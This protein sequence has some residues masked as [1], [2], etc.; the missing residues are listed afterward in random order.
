MSLMIDN[1]ITRIVANN[2]VEAS[3]NFLAIG[4]MLMRPLRR[5]ILCLHVTLQ[6]LFSFQCSALEVVVVMCK[7]FVVIEVLIRV[8][9]IFRMLFHL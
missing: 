9:P 5:V 6:F 2:L 7:H 1:A 3:R 8:S 4:S